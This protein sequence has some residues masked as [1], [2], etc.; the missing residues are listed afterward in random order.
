MTVPPRRASRV[1][2]RAAAAYPIRPISDSEF[3]AFYAVIEHAFNSSWPSEPELQ[4]ELP[5]IEFDRTLA[6]FDRSQMVGTAAAFTF[7]MTVPGGTAT[8]VE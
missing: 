5:T 4:H 8:V 3:P 2:L 7:Q 1:T 6:A